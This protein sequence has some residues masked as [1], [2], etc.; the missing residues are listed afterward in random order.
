VNK[1]PRLN[2]PCCTYYHQIGHQ[3]NDCPFI[4]N[5][6]RQVF[7]EHFQNLNLELA[8]IEDHGDFEPKDLYHEKAKISNRFK[9]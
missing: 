5:N 1:Y 3:I 4:K 6:A 8:R 9:D 2:P 7:A